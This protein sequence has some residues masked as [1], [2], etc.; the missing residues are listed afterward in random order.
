MADPTKLANINFLLSLTQPP[1]AFI[2][3]GQKF[4]S[5]LTGGAPV[6]VAFPF[7]DAT[8]AKSA[9]WT[10]TA[11]GA[12]CPAPVCG[13]LGTPTVTTNGNNVLSTVTYTPPASVPAGSGQN[14]PTLT[15]ATTANPAVK[16]SFSFHIVDGACGTG[17]NAALNGQYAFLLKGASATGGYEARAGSFT[18]DGNGNITGGL[19]DINR[20]SAVLIGS[21]LT[22]SYSVG[23]DNRGCLTLT[24]SAGG[25]GAFRIALGTM[26]GGIATQGAMTV[27]NDTTGQGSRLTGVLKRQNLTNLNSSTF[28]GTYAFGYEGVDSR[29]YRSAAAGLLTSDGAGNVTNI[30][31][32]VNVNGIAQTVT[33]LSGSYSLAPNAP[34]GRVIGQTMLG[35]G[36]TANYALYMISPSD[37]FIIGT[38]PTDAG[39]LIYSGGLKLQSGP[40]STGMLAS[41]SGYVLQ[42][43]GVDSGN[44]GSITILGQAQFTTN[45]GIATVTADFN[46]GGIGGTLGSAEATFTVDSSGRVTATGL[47]PR[48]PVFYLVDSTQGFIVG[49]NASVD[50]GYIERQTLTSFSTSTISGQF[51]FGGGAPTIEGPFESGTLNFSPGAPA[52]TITGTV[53]QSRPNFLLFCSQDCGGGGGLQPNNSFSTPYAFPAAPGAPGQFCLFGDC[54][55]DGVLGYIVSPSKIVFM[56]TGS[57]TNPNP[58]EVVIVQ[59]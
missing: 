22:G 53:D 14:F 46:G 59:Q 49:V 58:A 54:P 55:G 5:A 56:Q 38:D 30:N 1:H 45:T 21:T 37:L 11:N 7:P 12:T 43:F 52:G 26:S 35:G 10:L 6:A 40:F 16:D 27:F 17:A 57:S 34:G 8:A 39:H 18:A 25:T 31:M 33:D 44:G 13:T 20:S 4:A 2:G 23:P 48:P 15:A 42:I 51:F 47:G 19:V 50:F 3:Y 36:L 32:D 24:N 28:K 41:G 29:G 9:D